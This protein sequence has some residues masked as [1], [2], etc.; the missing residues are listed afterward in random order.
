MNNYKFIEG[1]GDGARKYFDRKC[2][3]NTKNLYKNIEKD[4]IVIAAHPFTK[5]SFMEWLFVKR[6]KWEWNDIIHDELCG[7]QILNGPYDKSF[8]RGVKIWK[9]LLLNGYKKFIYA[10]ND[11]HGNFNMYRQIKTPMISLKQKDE[12]ILGRSRTGIYAE[13]NTEDAIKALKQG[14]CFITNGPFIENIIY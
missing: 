4:A 14:K 12:Q 11:A 13:N 7:L 1:K 6:G 3:Y 2:K 5:V 8:Y 10:G 9:E